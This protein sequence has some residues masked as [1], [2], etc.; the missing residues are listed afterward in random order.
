MPSMTTSVTG[1]GVRVLKSLGAVLVLI[2]WNVK[3]WILFEEA[4]RANAN[5]EVLD[6]HTDV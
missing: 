1:R 2:A 5:S 6:W 4:D 3:R